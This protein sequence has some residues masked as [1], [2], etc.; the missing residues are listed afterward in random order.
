MNIRPYVV[1]LIVMALAAT[2]HAQ[3][4]LVQIRPQKG[5]PTVCRNLDKKKVADPVRLAAA[6]AL[7]KNPA[8]ELIVY[9][10]PSDTPDSP[11]HP[12]CRRFNV[13]R[14]RA[15]FRCDG[16]AKGVCYGPPIGLQDP[17]AVSLYFMPLIFDKATHRPLTPLVKPFPVTWEDKG[18]ECAQAP[19]QEEGFGLRGS[20][21]TISAV[22][23]ITM[24]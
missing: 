6:A 22:P 21:S 1:T 8:N 4:R 3:V 19:P 18:E 10:C 2:A 23:L 14:W 9:Y 12:G 16:N 15:V 20:V 17:R 24:M 7:L 5:N 11:E 13:P